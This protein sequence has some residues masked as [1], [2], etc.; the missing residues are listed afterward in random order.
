MASMD[1]KGDEVFQQELVDGI[2]LLPKVAGIYCIA[3]RVNGKRY[4][5]QSTNIFKRCQKHRTDLIR[6]IETNMLL[7]RDA[8]LHGTD[9]FFFYAIRIDGIADNARRFRLD[10]IEIWFATQLR[11]HDERFGYNMEVGHRRTRASRF[12]EQERKLMRVRS[13]KYML[14]DGIDLY[15]PIHPDLLA[16]WVPGR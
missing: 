11:T 2:S 12:R 8:A 4:V 15:D 3:N 14:R 16:S 10:M 7:L 5:G 6:G 13:S 1:T 9:S